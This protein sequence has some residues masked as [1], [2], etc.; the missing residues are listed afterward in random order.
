M[1]P[2][3]LNLPEDFIPL[4]LVLFRREVVVFG[5]FRGMRHQRFFPIDVRVGDPFFIAT[6]YQDH[7]VYPN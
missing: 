4:R 7:C 1:P 3:F 6:S 5:A 2:Y